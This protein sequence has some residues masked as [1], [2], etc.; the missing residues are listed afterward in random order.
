MREPERLSD[1]P[2]VPKLESE[3]EPGAE[4]PRILGPTQFIRCPNSKP[5]RALLEENGAK[6]INIW[7]SSKP[8]E[9]L[10]SVQK[11]CRNTLKDILGCLQIRGRRKPT[12]TFP[13]FSVPSKFMASHD[14][15][16][17]MPVVKH[18]AGLLPYNPGFLIL[19]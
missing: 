1:L 13:Q 8:K 3:V 12:Q 10:T 5:K 14:S 16:W 9:I 17:K 4:L 18:S 15:I 6:N 2:T 11:S 7:G 19:S